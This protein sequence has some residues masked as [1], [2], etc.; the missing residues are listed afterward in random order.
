MIWLRTHTPPVDCYLVG[1][2][3]GEIY[4]LRREGDELLTD[5]LLPTT[6]PLVS[7]RPKNV[8]VDTHPL[9][10]RTNILSSTTPPLLPLLH[11]ISTLL[12][13]TYLP[14]F[15]S[16][17]P[18]VDLVIGLFHTGAKL[19]GLGGGITQELPTPAMAGLRHRIVRMLLIHDNE[20]T[21]PTMTSGNDLHQ[22]IVTQQAPFMVTNYQ[23][24]HMHMTSFPLIQP[25]S[26]PALTLRYFF[27]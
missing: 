4:L 14:S 23:C 7:L 20:Q 22:Q 2:N 1:S 13:L 3:T 5:R 24:M 27:P 10:H 15:F 9:T 21:Q 26:C 6:K 18:L 17:P 16:H 19:L 11:Y 25:Y 12:F 8:L